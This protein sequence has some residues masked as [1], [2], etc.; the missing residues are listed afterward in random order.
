MMRA[1]LVT[2]SKEQ[3]QQQQT[4]ESALEGGLYSV[5][6]HWKSPT[7]TDSTKPRMMRMSMISINYKIVVIGMLV[8]LVL[9]GLFHSSSS[10][11]SSWFWTPQHDEA[12][13]VKLRQMF[14][15]FDCN[16]F[17]LERL[18]M[19]A[20]GP[21]CY[22]SGKTLDPHTAVLCDFALRKYSAVSSH[23][24]QHKFHETL[25]G[26]TTTTTTTKSSS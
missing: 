15:A 20:K 5:D 7:T 22:V 4:I 3:Q 19:Q 11:S 14:G 6:V 1:F 12:E 25:L 2:K 13:D 26:G 17:Y 24:K 21:T 23:C 10:S 8:G 18:K 16:Y 9:F